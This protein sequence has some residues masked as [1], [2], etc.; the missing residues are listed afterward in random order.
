VTRRIG[1]LLVLALLPACAGGGTPSTSPTRPT[2]PAAVAAPPPT[3]VPT[4]DGSDGTAATS[5]TAG[6]APT[7]PGATPVDTAPPATT[8]P[9]PTVPV[10]PGPRPTAPGT[11][12]P[13]PNGPGSTLAPVTSPPPPG[14]PAAGA[15]ACIPGSWRVPAD[16]LF[17]S[18]NRRTG[19]A[20]R[21]LGAVELELRADGNARFRLD[22]VAIDYR[23]GRT[24]QL[25]GHVAGQFMLTG[26][27]LAGSGLDVQ[28]AATVREGD[29]TVDA[30]PVLAEVLQTSPLSGSTLACESGRMTVTY[31]SPPLEGVQVTFARA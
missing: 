7:G 14:V 25:N 21:A 28:V 30:G 20:A 12:I 18:V 22:A 26:D 29:Q 19:S 2:A 3:T 9:P 17:D 23:T 5:S 16:D 10:P 15:S 11:G 27:R 24:A 6:T 13:V 1:A 4:P 31:V 8:L